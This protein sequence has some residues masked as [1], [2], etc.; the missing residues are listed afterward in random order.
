MFRKILAVICVVLVAILITPFLLFRS[1]T[2]SYLDPEFYKGPVLEEIYDE[3]V[4]FVSEEIQKDEKVANYFT[5]DEVREIISNNFPKEDIEVILQDFVSQIKGIEDRRK[6][7]AINVSLMPVKNNIDNLAEDVSSRIVSDIP[8]CEAE[9]DIQNVPRDDLGMPECIPVTINSERIQAPLKNEIQKELN[10]AVPGEF[11]LDLTTGME[12]QKT[13][14]N[15][16]VSIIEY[17]QLMLPFIILILLL[18]IALLI[19]SPYHSIMAYI[20]AALFSGGTLSIII[21]QFINRI[22]RLAVNQSNMPELSSN[23]IEELR[24]LY[25]VLVGFISDRMFIYSLYFAGAGAVLILI[26]LFIKHY[27]GG[28]NKTA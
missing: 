12:E 15:Q 24:G 9:T 4:S 7:D 25:T 17:I 14:L 21:V 1:I 11:T 18:L 3:F 8:A 2:N 16:A 27:N 23:E 13:Y 20:G 28:F 10:N 6:G 22:P 19:Y 5:V 26:A